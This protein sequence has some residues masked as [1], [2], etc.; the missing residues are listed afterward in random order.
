MYQTA[1]HDDGLLHATQGQLR[2]M[3]AGLCCG[4]PSGEAWTLLSRY[5]RHF[6]AMSDDAAALGMRLLASP[7]GC[8]PRIISGESGASGFGLAAALLLMPELAS[9]R[10]ALGLNADSR[11][12]CFSTEGNTDP[13]NWER[14]VWQGAQSL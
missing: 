3:M 7:C 4:E 14:V 8:D 2:S 13:A 5:A 9:Q 11:I 1:R 12:L 6:A 10:E